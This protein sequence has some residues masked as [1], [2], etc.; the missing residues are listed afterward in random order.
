MK[1]VTR[2]RMPTPMRE[3]ARTPNGVLNMRVLRA[4][5]PRVASAVVVMWGSVCPFMLRPNQDKGLRAASR[6]A[7]VGP[8]HGALNDTLPSFGMDE[9][10]R[11]AA[12]R[13][14]RLERYRRTCRRRQWRRPAR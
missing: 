12:P 7:A 11:R 4:A 9:T 14:C 1:A 8:K 5:A 2:P 3:N 10:G 6:A 13:E